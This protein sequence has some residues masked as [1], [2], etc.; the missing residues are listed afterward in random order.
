MQ[1]RIRA[2]IIAMALA[3]APV[4]GSSPAVAQAMPPA[5]GNPLQQAQRLAQAGNTSGALQQIAVARAAAT[6]PQ[7]RAAV[8]QMAAFVHSR[9]GNF[10]AAASEL[11]RVGA[12]PRTLAPYYYRAGNLDK[13][14]ELAKRAGGPD[15]QVIIAQSY[16]R[17]GK[18]KDAI[19]V[20]QQLIR[21]SGPRMNWLQNLAS[22]QFKDGDKAGY[23]ETVRQIIRVDPSPANWR[24]LLVNMRGQNMSNEAKLA[25]YQLMID[26]GNLTRPEDFQD[27]AKLAI[28][29]NQ[30]G[31]ARSVL[32]KAVA[33]KAI[34]PNDAMT[35]RLIE[36]ANQRA[37][38]ADAELARLPRTGEG[39]YKAGL[40]HFGAERYP[41]AATSLTQAVAARAPNAEQARMLA[42]ISLLRGGNAAGARQQF[43]AIPA[44]SPF[45]DIAEIWSLYAST[46][47]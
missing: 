23:M 36:A 28:L 38:A 37:A 33:A 46:R 22:A 20:Y 30:P 43:A 18:T 21:T 14:I 39:L 45:K 10:A 42:G 19:G 25:L 17:Q 5:V 12:G 32:N 34:D 1:S 26:T 41:A 29:D 40:V 11:E 7:Q 3:G 24:T 35:A 2:A 27:F 8:A 9:A 13:A 47:S 31:A 15:M 4:L 6:T 16:I 44:G